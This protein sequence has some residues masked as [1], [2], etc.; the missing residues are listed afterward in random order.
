MLSQGLALSLAGV[1]LGIGGALA[2]N[3]LM[4]GLLF[5]LS[6][7]NPTTYFG[8]AAL[9]IGVALIASYIP[10]R[11]ANRVDPMGSLRSC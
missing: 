4:V 3:H 9:F 10:A 5:Q 2:L 1:V 11:R 7:T 8:V 6:A